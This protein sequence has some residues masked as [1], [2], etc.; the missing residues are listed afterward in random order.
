VKAYKKGCL[1]HFAM[2]AFLSQ[3]SCLSFTQALACIPTYTPIWC[4]ACT[5]VFLL[6]SHQ[7]PLYTHPFPPHT[8]THKL[9][10]PPLSPRHM[11]TVILATLDPETQRALVGLVFNGVATPDPA[12]RGAVVGLCAGV[13]AVLGPTWAAQEVLG[14][15]VKQVRGGGSVCESL[16]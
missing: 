12:Q 9:M 13:A 3:F 10:P 16:C 7:N 5:L 2:A 11:Q 6:S 15:C 8:C 1:F 4:C 14:M